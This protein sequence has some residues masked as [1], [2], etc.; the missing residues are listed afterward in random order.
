MTSGG[1]VVHHQAGLTGSIQGPNEKRWG[2]LQPTV[3]DWDGDGK[4]EIITNDIFGVLTL[5]G[6]TG[7]PSDLA[8]PAVFKKDGKTY[9]SAWRSRPAIIPAKMNF[10]GSGM[11]TLLHMDWDGDL[12]VAIPET[13]GCLNIARVEKLAYKDGK[14]IVLCGPCGSWGRAELSVVDWNGDGKWDIVF[15]TIRG[16]QRFYAKDR[17]PGASPYWLENAG[18]NEKPVFAAARPVKL[19]N[20]RHIDFGI[21]TAA[22]CPTDLDND[23]VPDLIVGAEDGKTY[24]FLR[25]ELE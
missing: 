4:A 22:A 12:A 15:G 3:G 8:A 7:R 24:R 19:R 23:G 20:G 18:T 5:Y 11:P 9:K 10:S 13:Q 14:P 16:N 25:S 2:Y 1:K 17:G 21:H 6:A